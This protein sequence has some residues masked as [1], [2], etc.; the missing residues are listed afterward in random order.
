MKTLTIRTEITSDRSLHL[1]LSED[2]PIGPVEVVVV[3]VPDHQDLT[4]SVGTAAE[5]A[6][7]PLF[8]LWA[9]RDDVDDSL[10]YARQL[11][12]RAERRSHA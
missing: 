2:V 4:T 1:P 6:N 12:A 5:L 9:D 3:I 10:E 8:G 7:S 11:R